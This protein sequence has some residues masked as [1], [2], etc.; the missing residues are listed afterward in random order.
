MTCSQLSRMTNAV[1]LLRRSNSAASPPTFNA[2]TSVSTTSSGVAAVS[3]LANQ[4]PPGATPSDELSLRPTEIATA[5]LPTPPGPTISTS[6]P[7]ASRS[8]IAATSVSR[9]TRS[10]EIDGRFPAGLSGPR[11]RAVEEGTPSAGSWTRIWCSSCCSCTSRVEA[12]LVGQPVP[13]SLVRR[14]R[15]GL[16][17]VAVQGDHQQRPQALAQRMLADESFELADHLARGAEVEPCRELVLDETETDL[18]EAGTVRDDPVAITGGGQDLAPEQRQRRRARLQRSGRVAGASKRCGLFG[19]AEHLERIDRAR[20]DL[21]RVTGT[22]PRHQ[23]GVAQ[24][25][26]QPG[27][28]RLQHVARRADGLVSPEILDQPARCGPSHRP[29]GRDEP[30]LRSSCHAGRGCAHRRGAARR[31]RALTPRSLPTG[32][33]RGF[34][35]SAVSGVPPTLHP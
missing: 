2:A 25:P 8:A 17:A 7:S 9:P 27:H 12:E 5:V 20:V 6:R 4:T 13:G 19:E 21:Q 11:P 24:R 35:D 33:A 32:Y 16:A 10:A 22:R 3:S 14:Q 15:I 23:R 31:H 18:L 28:L 29:R 34:R 30:A 26:A 1:L